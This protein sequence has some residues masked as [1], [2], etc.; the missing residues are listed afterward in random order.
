MYAPAG[1]VVF[2]TMTWADHMQRW[3]KQMIAFD[4]VLGSGALLVV[5]LS[6]GASALV[7]VAPRFT[8]TLA[9][10]TL[11]GASLPGLV[12]AAL[13]LRDPESYR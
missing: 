7:Q 5:G 12:L 2:R 11:L 8:E 3:N 6:S 4:L 13:V 1:P 10:V 9:A